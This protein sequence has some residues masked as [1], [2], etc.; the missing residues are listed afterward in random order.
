[1][2]ELERLQELVARAKAGDQTAMPELR[3]LMEWKSACKRDPDRRVIGTHLGPFVG[4]GLAASE[5]RQRAR[6][7]P[8]KLV[9]GLVP[10]DSPILV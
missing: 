4:L 1:M 2:D 3:K 7:K 9:T 6:V 10:F 8:Q 5:S